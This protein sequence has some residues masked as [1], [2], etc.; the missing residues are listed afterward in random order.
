[1][2]SSRTE[3][4][5]TGNLSQK[6]TSHHSSNN[7]SATGN[8]RKRLQKADT[9]NAKL[10]NK[11]GNKRLVPH[12]RTFT[13]CKAITAP[14]IKGEKGTIFVGSLPTSYIRQI[15]DEIHSLGTLNSDPDDRL[16]RHTFNTTPSSMQWEH[17]PNRGVTTQQM[18]V[19][20]ADGMIVTPRH[21]NIPMP[22]REEN[23]RALLPRAP[24]SIINLIEQI[25][26]LN[27]EMAKVFGH[28]AI[29]HV[30]INHYYSLD[31]SALN[32]NVD[33]CLHW[34]VDK[35]KVGQLVACV[36]LMGKR[37]TLIKHHDSELE[38][39]STNPGD[40]Y[41]FDGT[42]YEHAVKLMSSSESMVLVL[43]S[44]FVPTIR[45]SDVFFDHESFK[46]PDEAT[47]Y[48][49]K[50][51]SAPLWDITKNPNFNVGKI[52]QLVTTKKCHNKGR[53]DSE[54]I[55]DQRSEIRDQRSEIRDQRSEISSDLNAL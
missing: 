7:Q 19:C 24:D 30:A 15:N 54:E 8:T 3:S 47:L 9:I 16:K 2:Y 43:R 21:E 42:Q 28:N 39:S 6:A 49:I 35:P 33:F 36:N 37:N 17:Y 31:G 45:N 26:K 18:R 20:Y 13:T 48:Q 55:R 40:F 12:N 51:L 14:T 46:L 27:P 52:G 4:Q 32:E 22:G 1:M 10:P 50:E 44:P 23:E 34:H 53:S 5:G 41:I 25:H 29:R 11:Q 38:I